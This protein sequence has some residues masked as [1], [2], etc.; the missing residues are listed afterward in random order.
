[1]RILFG[2]IFGLLFMGF[3]TS[4]IQSK[5]TMDQSPGTII[6][7]KADI[8]IEHFLS[9]LKER[10]LYPIG[11]NW[12]K[13]IIEHPKLKPDNIAENKQLKK[14]QSEVEKKGGLYCYYNNKKECLYVG[15]AKLL[16]DRIKSHYRESFTENNGKSYQ[17]N[18]FFSANKGELTV[19]WIEIEDE[20][21]R[22]IIERLI[23]Y[24]EKPLF[25]QQIP[26]KR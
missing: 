16:Y 23:A 20:D 24:L 8:S 1:M 4:F 13:F 26:R 12:N 22:V 10:N 17:W 3:S 18:A 25:E 21:S 7:F 14:I 11:M 9:L 19:Y 2:F 6:K 5:K 15:K